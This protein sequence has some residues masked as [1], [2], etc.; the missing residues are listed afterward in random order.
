MACHSIAA[1]Y[2]GHLRKEIIT[3]E[4]RKDTIA[5]REF[6]KIAMNLLGEKY[7]TVLG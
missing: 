5:N 3:L 4:G 7:G 6:E 2:S 1:T